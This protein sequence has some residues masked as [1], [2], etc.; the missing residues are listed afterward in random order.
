MTAQCRSYFVVLTLHGYETHAIFDNDQQ[1]SFMYIDYIQ[2]HNVQTMENALVLMLQDIE[3]LFC[4]SRSSLSKF[5]FPTP[6]RVLTEVEK[7]ISKRCNEDEM[8]RQR[9]LLASLNLSCPNNAEQQDAYNN[10]MKSIDDFR[11]TDWDLL[12]SH[13]FHFIGRP[14]GMEKS[15]LF[16]KLHTACHSKG[17]LI[18]ICAAASLAALSF[19]GAV[20]AHSL[21]GYPVEDEDNVDDLSPT[22]CEVMEEQADFFHEVSLIFWDEYISNDLNLMEA[23]LEQLKCYGGNHSIMCLYVLVILLR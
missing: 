14:G 22:Q 9:G 4:K 17:L 13:Q 5:G 2:F 12:T 15:A 21:F 3:Q 19:E 16:K 1:R 6:R 18:A 7:A 8:E 11:D 10:I 23:V 20:T